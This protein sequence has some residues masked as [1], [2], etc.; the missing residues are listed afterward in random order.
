MFWDF[1]QGKNNFNFV[2]KYYVINHFRPALLFCFPRIQQKNLRF[3]DVF[4]ERKNG[5]L[6][7]NGL[8]HFFQLKRSLI[9]KVIFFYIIFPSQ[10]LKS[11]ILAEDNINF[12]MPLPLSYS[13][14]DVGLRI[15]S[16]NSNLQMYSCSWTGNRIFQ[17]TIKSEK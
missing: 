5:I 3:S 9:T 17:W 8:I 2:Q 4:R 11:H 7:W 1:F 12:S 10:K 14:I 16:E 6:A 15:I 13:Y